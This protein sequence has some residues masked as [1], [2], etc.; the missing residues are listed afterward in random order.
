MSGYRYFLKP[1]YLPCPEC[2]RVGKFTRYF[3]NYRGEFV[4][5]EVGKCFRDG[6]YNYTPWDYRRDYPEEYEPTPDEW[7]PPPE[8]PISYIPSDV[9]DAAIPT[10]T[11]HPLLSYLAALTSKE[12]VME[13]VKR[14]KV[15]VGQNGEIM[16]PMI[17]IAGRVREIKCMRYLPNG[18]RDRGEHGTYTLHKSMV[19]SGR[20]KKGTAARQCFFGEHLLADVEGETAVAI[21]ESEKTAIYCSILFP[22]I[23]LATGS[24]GML[25]GKMEEAISMLKAAKKVVI[26]PDSGQ[27]DKW[28]QVAETF[29][30]PNCK[31]SDRCEN[32]PRNTDI[33]DLLEF[34]HTNDNVPPIPPSSTPPPKATATPSP[35]PPPTP[36]AHRKREKERLTDDD[37][38]LA[39]SDPCW[40]FTSE[41]LEK[42]WT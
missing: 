39:C 22:G 11:Q 13:A 30:L 26:Y 27:Y 4:A 15:G 24:C 7:A 20:L 3:D 19:K 21:A 42:V 2:G 31:V 6:C 37:I 23:W 40:H 9:V 35:T 38:Y 1:P 12:K 5:P 17:D 28:L 41:E 10:D 32:A 36:T 34:Y 16:F 33:L 14:Y 18:H 29:N 8:T 25:K